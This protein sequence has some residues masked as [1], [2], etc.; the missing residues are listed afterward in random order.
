MQH[1]Y[2]VKPRRAGRCFEVRPVVVIRFS[3][4]ER[5]VWPSGDRSIPICSQNSLLSFCFLDVTD[6]RHLTETIAYPLWRSCS[7]RMKRRNPD[8]GTACHGSL[9]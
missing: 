6:D 7:L 3:D 4:A 1:G 9:A 2:P 8:T 5:V